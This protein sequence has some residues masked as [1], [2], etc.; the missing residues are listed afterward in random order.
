MRSLKKQKAPKILRDNHKDWL[1]DYKS[2]TSNKTK[3]FRYRHRDIKTTLKTET[4]G[5][6]V[7]CESKIGHNTPGDVEHMIPSSKRINSHFSWINLTLACTECN[8]RKNNYY[9]RGS[10]FLNPYKDAVELLLEHQGPIVIWRAGNARAEISLRTL[11]LNTSKRAE[12]IFRKIE[13]VEQ[14]QNLYER[15]V[16][17]RNQVLKTLLASQLVEMTH[18]ESEFSAMV[19]DILKKKGFVIP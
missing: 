16:N 18:K 9:K 7:Y 2:D 5:K 3:K 14:V 6:C 11:E 1:I 17:E 12:L 13:K 15:Y 19:I 4:G 8:R 10:A